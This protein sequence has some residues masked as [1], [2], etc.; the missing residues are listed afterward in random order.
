MSPQAAVDFAGIIQAD[1]EQN[2]S[3][4]WSGTFIQYL[5]R[6]R[7]NP[8]IAQ[9]AHARLHEV[10]TREGWSDIQ[11][12][13]SPATRRLFGDESLKVYDFFKD[14]FFGIER[15][16]AQIVRYLHSAALNG[17]EARQVLYMMGPVGAGKSSIVEKLKSAL[18][19][20]DPV[21]A[22]EGCPMAEE[23]LHLLPSQLREEFEKML[24][25][26]IEGQLCPICRHRLDHEFDGHY[27]NV[28]VVTVPFSKHRRRGIGV[29][30]PVDPN[31]QDT[32]VLIGSEDISKLDTY[33]ENDPRVLDLNGAFNVGNRGV[34]EFIEVFKNEVEYLH[35]MITA[36]QEKFIPA[37][38]RHGTDL[39]RRGD[40]GSFERGRVAEVQGRSH[41]R[42]DSRSHRRRQGALQHADLGRDQDLSRRCCARTP[43]SEPTSR[44]IPWRWP[45]CSPS[46]LAWKT[47]AKV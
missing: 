12:D 16:C 25:T 38:G 29:V 8:E 28:P 5:E 47:T 7:Q 37:P 20:C 22:I 46:S 33:S 23:P 32:S 15:A 18:E 31:N 26:K 45:R 10:V 19:H 1:R 21:Y 2:D 43:T 36:T 14:E 39:C 44:P 3:R 30:P 42:S 6:V 34:V 27:E 24:G 35:T 41:Q 40:R 11:E 17:E 4:S 9:L 13:A